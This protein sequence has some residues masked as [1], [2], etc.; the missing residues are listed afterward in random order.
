MVGRAS[1]CVRVVAF[2]GGGLGFA[3]ARSEEVF[4]RMVLRARAKT[5][6]WWG[7]SSCV[8]P[9]CQHIVGC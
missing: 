5:R 6:E 1:G 2:G 4:P 7:M 8:G 9:F 3:S